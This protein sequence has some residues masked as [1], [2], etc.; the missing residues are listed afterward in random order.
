MDVEDGQLHQKWFLLDD[1]GRKH[2]A[3]TGLGSSSP[4]TLLKYGLKYYP[5][6]WFDTMQELEPPGGET[7]VVTWLVNFLEP[8]S[9]SEV[10]MHTLRR[11]L[12]HL[13]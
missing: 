7:Q 10:R 11:I 6:S 4:A 9:R 3:L 13:E 1:T 2:L 12:R 8:S 5:E